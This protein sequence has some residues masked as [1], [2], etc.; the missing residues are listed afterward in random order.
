MVRCVWRLWETDIHAH[1]H[2]HARTAFASQTLMTIDT[3]K[4]DEA[5]VNVKGGAIALGHPLGASGGRL[6]TSLLMEMQRT[7]PG[8]LGVVTLCCG[9]GYG[10][11]SLFVGE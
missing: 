3:L 7:G 9:T 11:S 10:V 1:A 5:K 8:Q 2:A 6:T 4:L